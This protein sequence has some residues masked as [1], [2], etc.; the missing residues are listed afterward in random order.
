MSK[1]EA[2]LK[3]AF[4]I[5]ARPEF[6]NGIHSTDLIRRVASEMGENQNTCNGNLYNLPN[7]F[8]DKVSRPSRGLFIL[9]ENAQLL[10]DVEEDK[11]KEDNKL[12]EKFL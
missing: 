12:D 3:K 10:D 5:L 11:S 6:K 4:E 7:Q 1:K 2:I 9:Q 8:P